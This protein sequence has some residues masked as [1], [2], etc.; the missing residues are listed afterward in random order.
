M[1]IERIY[2]IK[3]LTMTSKGESATAYSIKNYD[4]PS[5]AE[6]AIPD[7]FKEEFP[8]YFTVYCS[9]EPFYRIK[10]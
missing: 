7:N 6:K 9:I 10:K 1:E 5:Q 2:K 3:K 4:S 8:D